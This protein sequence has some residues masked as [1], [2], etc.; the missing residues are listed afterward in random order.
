MF[1]INYTLLAEGP[2]DRALLPIITWTLR[3]HLGEVAVQP[4]FADLSQ[5]LHPPKK[6]VDRIQTSLDLYPCDVLFV[7]RDT[8]NQG[9]DKRVQEIETA[10][11]KLQ[12]ESAPPIIGVIPIR[13]MEAWLMFDEAIIRRV[14]GNPSGRELLSLPLL[15]QVESIADPKDRINTALRVASGLRGRRLKQFNPGERLHLITDSIVDFSPLRQL[16][17]FQRFE[18]EIQSFALNF[19]G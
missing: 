12:L 2:S 19:L 16:S 15:K 6:L 5:L 17:A 9:M 11:A 1:E 4:S 13:M 8:D 3:Y 18:R 10:I 14:A 7:H